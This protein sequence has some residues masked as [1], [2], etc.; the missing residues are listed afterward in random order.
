MSQVIV[1]LPGR[2][3]RV[4]IEAGALSRLGDLIGMVVKNTGCAVVADKSVYSLYGA[5]VKESL[6]KAGFANVTEALQEPGEQNKTLETVRGHYDVLVNGRLDRN[7]PLI[8]LGGGV[9]G[10]TT[11]FVAATY[12]R[13]VPFVQC[14]TT[15]LAMVDASVG[16]K[17]GVD[18]PQGKNLVG[19]FYQPLLVVIDPLV[20]TSLPI[21]ELRC[22]L[23]ECIKHAMIADDS[24][25]E[26][27]VKNSQRIFDLEPGTLSELIER[28]V[29][30][31][32]RVV[33]EDETERG[34][35]AHLNFGHTF[36]HALENTIGYGKIEHG[37]GVALGMIA[38]SS[39][40]YEMGLCEKQVVSRLMALLEATGLPVRTELP[41]ISL[42]T[43]AMKKD[44]KVLVQKLRLVLPTGI[45]AVKIVDTASEQQLAAAWEAIRR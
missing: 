22:G 1:H 5:S 13:G 2:E 16:G 25:F 32:A 8:S 30:I 41:E 37:E 29:R 19:S 36:G 43:E 18:L 28:N 31:K 26:W 24:L 44:K 17:V 14:P 3:Y 21:R 4:V 9:V 27:I 10:D 20:L 33:E 38:A 15:L 34:V 12:L 42:L 45:G 23:A 35:R 11:G 40:A 6:L 39:L 7:C